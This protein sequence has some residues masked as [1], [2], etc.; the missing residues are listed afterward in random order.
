MTQSN[1]ANAYRAL[2]R[3]EESM[4][5]RREVYSGHLRLHGEGH[6]R[7][8][9][10]AFNYAT[11]LLQLQRFE[12]TKSL[13]LKTIPVAQRILGDSHDY[14][15]SMWSIYTNALYVDPASTLDDLREAVMKLEETERTARRVMGGAHPTTNIIEVSL[16]QARAVLR[17]RETPPGSS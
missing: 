10:A 2:G 1:L 15:I 12:E 13:M 5:L 11:A 7:T 8:L 4:S 16:Q 14:T 9:L 6:E 3:T 17:A